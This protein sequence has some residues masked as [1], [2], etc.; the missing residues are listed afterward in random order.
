MVESY[1]FKLI[2]AGNHLEIYDYKTK[3]I[4]RGFKKTIFRK[5]TK[6]KKPTINQFLGKPQNS[7][8]LFEYQ[9]LKQKAENER[10]E[11]TKFSLSRTRTNIRRII[12]S[13]DHLKT[14]LTLTFS[15]N[16]TELKEANYLFNQFIKRMKYKFKDFEYLA[17]PEFQKRGAVH[18][19][20]LCN[21]GITEFKTKSELFAFEKEFGKTC[22]KNGFVKFKAVK[23]IDNMGAYFC[24]YL[25]KDMFDKRAFGKKK[26]FRSQSL[27]KPFELIGCFAWRLFQQLKQALKLVFEKNFSSE[28]AGEVEYKAY[29]L[30]QAKISPLILT[31]IKE[32][33]I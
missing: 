9:E 2:K 11:K 1:S 32:L 25:G 12:N 31:N 10:K 27:A 5:I 17:V 3:S 15:E 23:D 13:N 4:L 22:W 14:F 21:L 33:K 16:I 19:H 28:W 30:D 6:I 24:K 18:Y 8:N 20:L 26:F 29:L 7:I